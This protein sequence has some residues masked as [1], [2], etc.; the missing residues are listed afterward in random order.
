MSNVHFLRE[1][2][3]GCEALANRERCF[4]ILPQARVHCH[5]AYSIPYSFYLFFYVC[6]QAAIIY[7]DTNQDYTPKHQPIRPGRPN[8]TY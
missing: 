5:A 6:T 3:R 1:D 7:Y 2:K 4:R 8:P